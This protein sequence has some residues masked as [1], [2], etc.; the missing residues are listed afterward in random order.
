MT[1]KKKER[2]RKFE[3][4]NN[5]LPSTEE[6]RTLTETEQLFKSNLFRLQLDELLKEIKINYK[7]TNSIENASETVIKDLKNLKGREISG[8]LEEFQGISTSNEGK[9]VRF[10][11][12]SPEKCEIFGSFPM[13]TNAKPN[14]NVDIAL[15]IPESCMK[16]KDTVNYR[17]H[18]KRN[19]YLKEVQNQLESKKKYKS[20]LQ[21]TCLNGDL[22]KPILEIHPTKEMGGGLKTNFVIRLHVT[23]NKNT[24]L[25]NRLLP[26]RNNRR[27]PKDENSNLDLSPTAIYNNSILED[28]F[29]LDH[30]NWMKQR[31]EGHENLIETILLIKIWMKQREM[32]GKDTINHFIATYLILYLIETRR[33]TLF[34]SSYQIF[35]VFLQFVGTYDISK[36]IFM[37]SIPEYK[38]SLLNQFDVVFMD[39][40]GQF[41][42]TGRMNKSSWSEFARDCRSSLSLL[43]DPLSDNFELLFL[44]RVPFNCKYDAYIQLSCLPNSQFEDKIES[45]GLEHL[46]KQS[47]CNTSLY[48]DARDEIVK[49]ITENIRRGLG[50]RIH[51]IR[52]QVSNHKNLWQSNEEIPSIP[53]VL[54]FGLIIDPI[55]AR[56]KIDAG[57]SAEDSAEAESFKQFWGKK[58]EMRRFPDNSILV[59]AVWECK[60]DERPMI[61]SRATKYILEKHH[62]I[63]SSSVYV[64]QNQYESFFKIPNEP[65][66][67]ISNSSIQLVKIYDEMVGII[68]N[69]ETLPISIVSVRPS[70]PSLRNT[71]VFPSF[72][73]ANTKGINSNQTLLHT[74]VQVIMQFQ[75][76][77]AWP[78]DLAPIE[79]VRQAIMAQMAMEIKTSPSFSAQVVE[80][81]SSG[82]YLIPKYGNSN[83]STYLEVTY[84]GPT[85]VSF[86]LFMQ[87]EK[88]LLKMDQLPA[89][90]EFANYLRFEYQVKPNY[91]GMIHAVSSRYSAYG[92]SVRLALRWLHSHLFSNHFDV[93]FVELLMGHIFASPGNYSSPSSPFSAFLRFL[94]LLVEFDFEEA[95]II[96]NVDQQFTADDILQIREEFK[97]IRKESPSTHSVFISTPQDRKSSLW[98]KDRPSRMILKRMKTFAQT[99][100]SLV[101][102]NFSIESS[103]SFSSNEKDAAWKEILKTNYADYDV[104]LKLSPRA[105]AKFEQSISIPLGEFNPNSIKDESW[106]V[107][108]ELK[109]VPKKFIS[110][111]NYPRLYLTELSERFGSDAL[112]FF[113]E[114]GGTTIAIVWKPTLFLLDQLKLSNASHS[115]FPTQ[116]PAPLK[117]KKG[118]TE[119]IPSIFGILSEIKQMG[120]GIIEGIEF[121]HSSNN[122]K[123][124]SN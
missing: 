56:S 51:L 108:K 21:W 113:D 33:V 69:L 116:V 52:P 54:C 55:E 44:R 94:R 101:E 84:K 76:S 32:N 6:I 72:A 63:D 82:I 91:H 75:V 87:V 80:S 37:K 68:N 111:M 121:N 23:M 90:K 104:L 24:H 7:K 114:L 65:D 20:I 106:K 59:C 67:S 89:M 93:E 77:K 29:Q 123:T 57:P 35:R 12:K 83:P 109:D 61:I 16:D 17:Y 53:N 98:T 86:H 34:M 3:S 48:S 1:E 99:A 26:N 79:K 8:D 60:D 96:M 81:P 49:N 102:K 120:E 31:I 13:K 105:I 9:K 5:S 38:E 88:E 14:L 25:I 71:S 85:P 28:L 115:I 11:F 2:K 39:H 119:V 103:P 50:K 40:S 64:L 118:A 70:H 36:G 62:Q 122:L 100:I 92:P 41:N 18:D 22:S 43:E 107:R 58:A 74:P 124:S 47:E 10:E 97:K 112:F 66:F 73:T 117:Q 78:A 19:L 42:L 15:F 27:S 30:F 110:G 4:K 46:P 45:F 95:P